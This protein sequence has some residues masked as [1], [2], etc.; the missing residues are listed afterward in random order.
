M[1]LAVGWGSPAVGLA[2]EVVATVTPPSLAVEVEITSLV[3]NDPFD[4]IEE[5]G[6]APAAASTPK[7]PTQ[8]YSSTLSDVAKALVIEPTT[9]AVA[10]GDKLILVPNGVIAGPPGSSVWPSKT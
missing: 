4:A 2:S 1:S 5:V 6:F 10:C 9:T 7:R 3:D 8:M